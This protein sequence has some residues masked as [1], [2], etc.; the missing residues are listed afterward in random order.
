[1]VAPTEKLEKEGPRTGGKKTRRGRKHSR[2][3]LYEQ[4]AQE[5]ES[6]EQDA[7]EGRKQPNV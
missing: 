3:E 2:K 1:M 7:Q 5:G 4:D 6:Y